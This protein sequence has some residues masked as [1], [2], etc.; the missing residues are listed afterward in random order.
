MA[1]RCSLRC[2]LPAAPCTLPRCAAGAPRPLAAHSRVSLV[3]VA[4]VV[5][6]SPRPS[7]RPIHGRMLASELTP[8][9]L[10]TVPSLHADPR[11][12][13][14]TSAFRPPALVARPAPAPP[15]PAPACFCI[16]AYAWPWPWP[17]RC[18]APPAVCVSTVSSSRL[19]CH[20]RPLFRSLCDASTRL[21]TVPPIHSLPIHYIH[22]P[23]RHPPLA[24]TVAL[25]SLPWF[26]ERLCTC[27]NARGVPS[28]LPSEPCPAQ[29]FS[30][31]MK[32]IP[33]VT[34][35][36]F[37]SPPVSP[38]PAGRFPSPLCKARRRP[39][40]VRPCLTPAALAAGPRST[41]PVSPP[42]S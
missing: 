5:A 31:R 22:I 40:R 24:P 32:T 35:C 17:W 8:S 13:A 10:A 4:V 39:L 18:L 28:P 7:N 38:S 6:A 1:A 41:L 21:T 42:S 23:A 3:V 27:Q 12:R 30:T 25:D 11:R 9:A 37:C 20:C 2:P 33:S 14:A 15:G 26:T 16:C 29:R 36:P 34:T 19:P